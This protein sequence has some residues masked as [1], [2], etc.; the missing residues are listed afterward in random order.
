MVNFFIDRP[1]FSSVISIVI[2]IAGIVSLL[3]LPIAQFPEI[4]PPQVEVKTTYAGAGADVVEMTVASPIEQEVNGVENMLY[5]SSKSANDGSMTLNV[6]FDVGTDLDQAAVNIQNR[7]AIAQ[8][9][10]PEEV[11]RNGITT[12]KKSTNLL[13]VVALQATSEHFDQLFLSNYAAINILDQLK[14]LPGVGDAKDMAAR[15]YG[16]RIW[17]NPDRLTNLDLTVTDVSNAIQR[18]ECSV[19]GRANWSSAGPPWA[20]IPIQSESKGAAV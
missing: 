14:R 10:L 4:T 16:M 1:I 8:S 12:K 11:V 5:M 19:R 13:M 3:G 20:G 15:D 2:L 6:T 17:L 7:V 18:T 9:K